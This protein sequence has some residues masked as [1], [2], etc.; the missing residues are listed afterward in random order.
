M[1]RIIKKYPIAARRLKPSVIPVV[2]AIFLFSFSG[3]ALVGADRFD[4]QI[5]SLS[6]QNG[7]LQQTKE[8]LN[9]EA[10]TVQSK[11]AELQARITGLEY[12]IQLNK[13]KVESLQQQIAVAE[14]ELAKQRKVLGQNIKIMHHEG[15]TST[16]EILASSKDISEF[17]D[18]ET[19]RQAV[20]Q[21]IK[22]S[23]NTVMT[24]K[25]QL[26]SD[27]ST[28]NKNLADQQAMYI[29]LDK[30]RAQN[31]QLLA[32]NLEQQ[33]SYTQ[34]VKQNNSQITELRRQQAIENAKI[35]TRGSA[36]K[37]IQGGGGYPAVWA[38]APMDSIV[39]TWGMYNRECVSYTAWKVAASGR[40]MPYWGG[41]GN[42]KQW[43]DNARAAGIPVDYSP[44]VGDVAISTRG[45]YGHSMYVE[46]VNSDG[47]LTVSQYNA[48]WDGNFSIAMV[49]PAGLQ[50]IHF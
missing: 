9:I 45:E 28:L 8:H 23:L 49:N 19:Y 31:D 41:I 39:D 24:L 44:R 35:F 46:A 3:A 42:A 43:P 34:Q 11:I 12:E 2:L 6:Q 47:T 37:G 29:Q 36:P 18:K 25:R 17:V 20:M 33:A 1:E 40:Y 30:Q 21:K 38:N 32:Y 48:A 27:K 16:L 15:Q 7:Q 4:E 10:E 13:N 14:T 22:T 26:D 50:F 5:N